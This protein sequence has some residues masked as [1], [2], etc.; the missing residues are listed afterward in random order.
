MTTLTKRATVYLEPEMHRA[1]Q[2]K[3]FE[4]SRSISDL[5]NDALRGEL[6]EDEADLAV[7][8]ARRNDPTV[9]LAAFVEELKRDGKI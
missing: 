5:I 2:L 8:A 9:S 3:A 6:A 7:F 1:L 4:T